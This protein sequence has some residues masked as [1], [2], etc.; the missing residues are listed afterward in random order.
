MR[1]KLTALVLAALL[2]L[3]SVQA[4]DM[5]D[6]APRF[7]KEQREE[8]QKQHKSHKQELREQYQQTR[9]KLPKKDRDAYQAKRTEL[10]EKH[11]ANMRNQ[12]TPEQLKAMED[13]KSKCKS[14]R[15]G[16]KQHKDGRNCDVK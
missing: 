12:L 6:R 9:E 14:D 7:S 10:N 8:M 11:R 16:R 4:E 5:K 1:M 13:R 15:K 2:P 3:A